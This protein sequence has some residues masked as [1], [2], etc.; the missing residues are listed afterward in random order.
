MAAASA[1]GLR[2]DDAVV[3]HAS[4]RI[5]VRLLPC[6]VLVRVAQRAHL[7][8]AETEVAVTQR[9]AETESPVAALDPRVAP[10]AYLRDGFV[11]T[12][13][14]YYE[15]ASSQDIAPAEYARALERLHSGLRQIDLPAPHFTDRIAEAQRLVGDRDQ[16]PEL[17]DTDR[18]ILRTALQHLRR[19]V[20]DR[21]ATEQLL[22]GEPHPGNLLR[23]TQGLLFVDWETCCRGPVEFDVAHAPEAVSEHY[24]H[25]DNILL[26]D[27]RL[28]VLAM[29]ATWRW[30]RDDQ[31]PHG[32]Q[33]GIEMLGQLQDALTRTEMDNNP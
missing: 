4:N 7:A 5:A 22:H 23:T 31:F 2:A 33:M 1:L 10:L 28:M 9:L 13:W 6:D 15:P 3:V 14:T 17:A 29:V 26:Y 20:V 21:A 30:E 25:L 32:R 16:T 8:S 12:F 18:D 19:N 27:C 24:P 11:I